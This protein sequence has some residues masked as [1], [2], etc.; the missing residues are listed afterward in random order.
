M[1]KWCQER[2]VPYIN[3]MLLYE[4][5]GID[6]ETDDADGGWH[7]NESGAEK[8]SVHMLKYIGANEYYTKIGED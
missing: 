1:E 8:V 2:D 3:Y 6:E 5:L 4:E 7:L